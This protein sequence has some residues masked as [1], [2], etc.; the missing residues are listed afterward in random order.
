MEFFWKG[1]TRIVRKKRIK[2]ENLIRK[3]FISYKIFYDLLQREREIINCFLRALFLYKYV[4][5]FIGV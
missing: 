3:I 5:K 4:N 1:Q 2:N